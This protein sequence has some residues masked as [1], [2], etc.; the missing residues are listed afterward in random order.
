MFDTADK[1]A[2]LL[3][4]TISAL[5][6]EKQKDVLFKYWNNSCE[7]YQDDIFFL[8]ETF[9][10]SVNTYLGFPDD[11][12]SLYNKTIR[13]IN[14]N[15]YL[16]LLAW[17]IH[18]LLYGYNDEQNAYEVLSDKNWPDLAQTMG[19][20]SDMFGV[21]ILS[22][23]IYEMLK[24]YREK[25]I[26]EEVAKD[27]LDDLLRWMDSFRRSEG[28]WGFRQQSWLYR[29]F[30]CRLFRFG[31]L[32]Y[33][34]IKF[35]DKIVVFRNN[36]SNDI[37]IFS[38]GDV[39]YRQDGQIDGTCGIFD[40]QNSWISE[41][42][43][44]EDKI[45]GNPITPDNAACSNKTVEIDKNQWHK[46]LDE[47]DDVLNVHIPEGSKLDHELCVK[48]YKDALQFFKKYYPELNP[49]AFVCNSWLLD[50]QLKKILGPE[51]NI[52]KFLEDFHAYPIYSPR[53]AQ[54]Y[55]RVFGKYSDNI[56]DLPENTSLQK[57][58]KE[59]IMN[60]NYMRNGAGFILIN[61]F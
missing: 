53:E 5:R 1:N 13:F 24:T 15:K 60:G 37:R 18:Q 4:E 23:G 57:K 19:E 2:G 27:T 58:I 29:H 44:T 45:T 55:E 51:S 12:L 33:E 21:V 48:S 30:T 41:Y 38:K 39:K 35:M 22:S 36:T 42:K 10:Y 40:N 26:P 6:L 17:H 56:E 47:N 14:S 54:A 3:N 43:E 46:V 28:R 49:K 8:D 20:L 16:K 7:S 52:I 59:Y 61:S 50:I 32:Q 11:V 34:P 25:G 9:I 31:R